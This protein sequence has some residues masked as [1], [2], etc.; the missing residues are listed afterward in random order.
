MEDSR[1]RAQNLLDEKESEIQGL[2]SQKKQWEDL[3]KKQESRLKHL[4]EDQEEYGERT[5]KEIKV[6]ACSILGR[7]VNQ[8]L[9]CA[10]GRICR[11]LRRL[12]LESVQV[13]RRVKAS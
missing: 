13:K 2:Q 11:G 5:Q 6:C 12:L 1:I 9:T 4:E 3:L 8:K 7:R 10:L